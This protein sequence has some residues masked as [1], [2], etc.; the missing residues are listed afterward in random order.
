LTKTPDTYDPNARTFDSNGAAPGGVVPVYHVNGDQGVA[1]D[2]NGIAVAIQSDK[3]ATTAFDTRNNIGTPTGPNQA[4]GGRTSAGDVVGPPSPAWL[5]N[6]L[7]Q[8]DGV[9]VSDVS[10]ANHAYGFTLDNGTPGVYTDDT[11]GASVQG[12]GATFGFGTEAG[13]VA[14]EVGDL[15]EGLIPRNAVTNLGPLP[16]L[17]SPD[18]AVLA[19]ELVSFTGSGQPSD[20]PAVVNPLTGEFS[21]DTNGSTQLGTYSAVIRASNTAGGDEGTLTFEIFVPEPASFALFG[22]A[23]VGMVGLVRRRNG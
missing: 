17:N 15:D 20:A 8:W 7:V 5:G 11:F 16:I 4:G 23:M 3:I 6:F 10:L 12:A 1:G 21:W 2:L 18:P 14:P 22:I 9:G 19:W 13:G